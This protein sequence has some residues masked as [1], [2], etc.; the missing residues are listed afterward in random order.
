M[1]ERADKSLSCHLAYIL[2]GIT[3]VVSGCVACFQF[4][5]G[6]CLLCSYHVADTYVLA[7]LRNFFFKCHAAHQVLD[8]YFCREFRIGIIRFL[9]SR[10]IDGESQ[11]DDD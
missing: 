6:Q 5:S 9:L 11:G 7:H 3:G 4:L 2:D 10:S 1:K 8:A